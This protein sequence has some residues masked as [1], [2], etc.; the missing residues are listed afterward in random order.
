MSSSSRLVIFEAMLGR[1]VRLRAVSFRAVLAAACIG[2]TLVG[3]SAAQ[4]REP[5]HAAVSESVPD[6]REVGVAPEC[7]DEK[8]QRVEC[9][10]DADCCA[11]FVCG[12]DPDLSPRV[13]YCIYGG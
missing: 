7:V 3:C 4:Q 2:G 1:A 11:G 6:T 12:K 5:G 8:D 13:S 9:L 10:S